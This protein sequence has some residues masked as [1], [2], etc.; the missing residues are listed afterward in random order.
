M[1]CEFVPH[2]P[3][4]R[5]RFAAAF[6]LLGWLAAIPALLPMVFAALGSL[7]R[8]HQIALEDRAG[9]TVIVLHH[10]GAQR[11]DHRHA[12][13]ARALTFFAENRDATQDHVLTFA[14]SG[15]ASVSKPATLPSVQSQTAQLPASINL[16]RPLPLS[17]DAPALAPRPPPICALALVCLRS[18]S[19][20]I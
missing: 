14:Q 9:R 8:Q 11:L 20:R 3:V 7:D 16:I 6:C 2:P 4:L 17:F 12:S 19:L 5:V 15:S 1:R 13:L 18:I 10:G